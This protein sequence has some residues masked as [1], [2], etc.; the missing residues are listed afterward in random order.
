M[1]SVS[2]SSFD[3][4][5]HSVTLPG[6]VQLATGIDRYARFLAITLNNFFHLILDDDTIPNKRKL[7]SLTTTAILLLQDSDGRSWNIGMMRPSHSSSMSP[8]SLYTRATTT[9]VA[10]LLIY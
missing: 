1:T 4:L 5:E 8:F 9:P 2:T 10:F 3:Q 6:S 7:A